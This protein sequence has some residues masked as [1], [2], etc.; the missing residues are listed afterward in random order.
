MCGGPAFFPLHECCLLVLSILAA[1]YMLSQH[2]PHRVSW[3]H[4]CRPLDED[5]SCSTCSNYSRAFLH[6]L[7]TRAGLPFAASLISLHNI[8]Y[9][10]RLTKQIRDAIKEHRFP[11]FVQDF[12]SRHYPKVGLSLH[13][14]YV[15]TRAVCHCAGC[16]STSHVWLSLQGDYPQWLV[17]ALDVAGIPVHCT[18]N[19]SC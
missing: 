7:T 3:G 8:A 11:E 13:A 9:T 12:V 5:C 2:S 18:A 14:P 1:E 16:V 17:G 6:N 19:N 10:Q 15:V 4:L